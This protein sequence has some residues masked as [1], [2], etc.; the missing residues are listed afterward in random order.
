[1]AVLLA[2]PKNTSQDVRRTM[3]AKSMNEQHTAQE[4]ARDDGV[5]LRGA[6][7]MQSGV[8]PV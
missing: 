2:T 8:Q 4:L 5:R 6:K 7:G 3:L 1:M